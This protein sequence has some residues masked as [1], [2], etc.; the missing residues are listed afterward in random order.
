[1]AGKA[2]SPG[3]AKERPTHSQENVIDENAWG[4]LPQEVPDPQRLVGEMKN[5]SS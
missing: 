4:V 3:G 5:L 2:Q 1:M